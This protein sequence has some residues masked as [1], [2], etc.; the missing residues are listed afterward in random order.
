MPFIGKYSSYT[1]S[2]L[3]KLIQKYCKEISVKLVFVTCKIGSNFSLKDCIPKSL[4][5]NV[6]YKFSCAGCNTCYIGETKRHL[7]TR[8]RE[9][10]V[11]D[12]NSHVYKHVHA[13]EECFEKCDS[14][15]FSILDSAPTEYQL[16]L[17]EA[18]HIEWERPSLN[19]QVKHLNLT[20]T[21]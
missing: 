14:R 11:S 5:S 6:V 7:E 20:I 9:H 3:E 12:K 4:K 19:R 13:S 21:V 16:K 2:K 15:C 8:I 18:M 1:K 17:K 10:L